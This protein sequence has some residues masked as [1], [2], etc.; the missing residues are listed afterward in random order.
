MKSFA[1]APATPARRDLV[2]PRSTVA[3]RNLGV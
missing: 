1:L 3:P 2:D